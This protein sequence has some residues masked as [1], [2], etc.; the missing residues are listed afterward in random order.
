MRVTPEHV[1]T[2]LLD[3][4]HTDNGGPFLSSTD[5]FHRACP[6]LEV[7]ISQGYFQDNPSD[8]D[9]SYWT[10]VA[11]EEQEA[12]EYFSDAYVGLSRVLNRIFEHP[13]GVTR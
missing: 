7:L 8:I 10:A 12:L 2:C 6:Y 1:W 5:D 4:L 13:Y 11:G 9:S 3:I